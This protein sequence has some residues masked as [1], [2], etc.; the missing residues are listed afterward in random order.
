MASAIS[1]KNVQ[2]LASAFNG[3][4]KS[5]K[6]NNSPIVGKGFDALYNSMQ[7]DRKTRTQLDQD[8]GMEKAL[9]NID[10]SI[11]FATKMMLSAAKNMGLPGDDDSNKSKEMSDSA[12]SI[13]QMMSTKAGIQ[14]QMAVVEAHKNPALDLMSLK[15]KMVDYK[16]DTRH[17]FAPTGKPVTY[18]YNVSHNEQSQNAVVNLSFTIRDASG[19]VVR[20]AS[21]VGGE[22]GEHEFVWDGK[23]NFGNKVSTGEY[24]L[25]VKAKGN[26]YSSGQLKSLHATASTTLSGIVDRVKIENGTAT[27]VY[28]NGKAI[29]RDQIS[30]VRDA[31]NPDLGVKLTTDLID[32]VVEL[33][34]SKAQVR[35]GA[36]QVYFKNNVENSGDQI[37]KIFD[38]S[39]KYIKTLTSTKEIKTGVGAIKFTP[40]QTQLENGNYK[41]EVYVQDKTNPDNIKD[42]KLKY[43]HHEAVAAVSKQNDTFMSH[44][45]NHF[46]PYSI[47]SIIS[48]NYQTP[49]ARKIAQ[50]QGSIV[51]FRDDFFQF[52]NGVDNSTTFNG[53]NKPQENAVISCT[54]MTIYDTETND[55]VAIIRSEYKPYHDLD[56]E[57]KNKLRGYI[58]AQ[59]NTYNYDLL[60]S[61]E[62]LELNRHIESQ[63]KL[64]N[65]KVKEDLQESYDKG[66]V[67]MS[68]PS[69]NGTKTGGNI[70]VNNPLIAKDGRTY[71]R[72]FTP[73]YIRDNDGSMVPGKTKHA[74]DKGL[75]ESVEIEDGGLSCSLKIAGRDNPISEDLVQNKRQARTTN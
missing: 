50:Y 75:V 31:E 61:V 1:E 16:D 68:F 33:D 41:V 46:S 19:R 66:L 65:L 8:S 40:E 53:I 58:H 20:T 29:S 21:H 47:N 74:F 72:E 5:S 11:D 7:A 48:G 26:K 32:K 69:W 67:A 14:A 51:S 70:A 44:N 54:N 45:A 37:V 38:E 62:R 23:D 49:T 24:T 22:V 28:I 42:I 43:E 6:L 71:R 18:R 36:L 34:F 2:A 9:E 30:D 12:N 64:D 10:K 52:N 3:S 35:D 60:S 39:G 27:A 59:Y 4:K 15:G 25:Q 55:L 17:F 63:L 73:I 56:D 57:S 13:A